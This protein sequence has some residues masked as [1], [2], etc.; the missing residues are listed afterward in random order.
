MQKLILRANKNYLTKNDFAGRTGHKPGEHGRVAGTVSADKAAISNALLNLNYCHI[1]APIDGKTGSLQSFV[2]NVVKAPD[3]TLLTITQIRPIY[4]AFAVPEQYL[5]EIKKQ[6]AGQ[7]LGVAATF[8]NMDRAAA[9]GGT[10]FRGQLG[11]HDN[12]EPF[13]S[14]PRSRMKTTCCGLDNS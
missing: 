7:T 5:P 6:M 2:G 8:E 13:C 11:G 10:E 12:A 9:A 4:V 14:K 3:D 1:R